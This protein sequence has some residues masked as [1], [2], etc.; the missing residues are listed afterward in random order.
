MTNA[1]QD[2]FCVLWRIKKIVQVYHKIIK[3]L[4]LQTK[5]GKKTVG[6]YSLTNSL[7]VKSTDICFDVQ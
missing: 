6:C 5:K 4:V 2:Y 1:I 3:V 7:I